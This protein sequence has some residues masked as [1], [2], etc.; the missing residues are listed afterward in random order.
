MGENT[1]QAKEWLDKSYGTYS[2]SYTTVK[3]WCGEFKGGR[4]STDDA[5]CLGRTNEA[6]TEENIKKVHRIVLDDRKI[7]VGEIA[8]MVRISTRRVSHILHEHL[9]IKV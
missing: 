6:V 4:A 3:K 5:E 9:G 8:D 1:T 2:S 7:K